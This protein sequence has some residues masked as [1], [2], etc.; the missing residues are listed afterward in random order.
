M[1]NT[2]KYFSTAVIALA[3][4]GGLAGCQKKDPIVE[5]GPAERAGQQLDQAASEAGKK[6]N[7]VAD[8]AGK[9]IEKAGEKIQNAAKDAQK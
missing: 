9:E 3:L 5:R 6:L 2:I 7:D 1:M 4:A 8:K